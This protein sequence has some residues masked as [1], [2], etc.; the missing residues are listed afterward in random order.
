MFGASPKI[1]RGIMRIAWLLPLPRFTSL[2]IR[3][4]KA[5]ETNPL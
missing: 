1:S 2:P 5:I 3:H 4:R